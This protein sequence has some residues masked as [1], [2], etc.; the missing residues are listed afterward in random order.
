MHEV[1]QTTTK[2]RYVDMTDKEKVALKALQ[3]LLFEVKLKPR[4]DKYDPLLFLQDIEYT[5]QGLWGF[6]R[7]KF[8]H[9]HTQDYLINGGNV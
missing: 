1:R 2:D 8:Y 9:I 4:S 6:S 3:D 5:L 7:D